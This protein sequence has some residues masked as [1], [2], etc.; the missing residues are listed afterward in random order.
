[1]DEVFS[2][3]ELYDVVLKAY[4]DITINNIHYNAGD[5]ITKFDRIS[6]SNFSGIK[7]NKNARGGKNNTPYVF[8][9]SLKEVPINFY[10]G[11]FSKEQF[12]LMNNMKIVSLFDDSIY[13]TQVEN[14][15]SDEN[16]IIPT[17]FE[18]QRNLR[19]LDQ[20]GQILPYTKVDGII[21]IDKPYTDVYVSY[22]F[23][24]NNNKITKF[25][26]GQKFLNGFISLEGRTRIKEEDGRVYTG[27]L[28]IYK[29][30]ITSEIVMSLGFEAIPIN[31]SFSA[32]AYPVGSGQEQK[33]AD[34]FIL[35]EDIDSDL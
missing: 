28:K 9:D 7:Q 4:S 26:I 29:M 18:P 10:Q 35:G 16:G 12:A 8:W 13:I 20:N 32:T 17:K 15:E 11:V 30:R 14:R 2:F 23:L 31:G 33:I 25:Q 22:D 27:I 24:Y 5:V 1:M 3:K 34:L 21:K 6:T 19:I